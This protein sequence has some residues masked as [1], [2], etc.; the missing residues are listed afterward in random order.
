MMSQSVGFAFSPVMFNNFINDLN[1]DSKYMYV[2]FPD[3]ETKLKR[4][5]NMLDDSMPVSQA[6]KILTGQRDGPN[7]T[8]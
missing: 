8:R 4:I 7:L 2:T 1:E 5:G 6:K 3:D